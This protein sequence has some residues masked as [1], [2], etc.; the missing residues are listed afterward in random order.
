[1]FRARTSVSDDEAP[2]RSQADNEIGTLIR[3][4]ASDFRGGWRWSTRPTKNCRLFQ[5]ALF[6]AVGLIDGTGN[7]ETR[8][9]GCLALAPGR[10]LARRL[11][12]RRRWPANLPE[13]GESVH[14]MN[15][16]AS[17]VLGQD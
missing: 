6:D 4:F 11:T 16:S 3:E 2:I 1:M 17:R 15:L 12:G 8:G 9:T 10:R 14:E 5:L 13:P 7:Y